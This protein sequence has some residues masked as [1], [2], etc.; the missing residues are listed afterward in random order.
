[1][2][3]D[4]Y[5]TERG[6]C[7]SRAA[8]QCLIKDGGVL[9]NG[10]T[11]VKNSLEVTE[12]DKI[13]IIDIKLPKYVGRGGQKLE[14]ALEL[15]NVDLNGKLC[16]DIGASTGGFT[17]CMLQNG[18]AKVFAVDVG[19]GQLAEKLRSDSRV[20][21]MEQT[22][23]RDF[24][25]P[26]DVFADFIGADVSFIS[27]RLILPHIY[28]LLK[29]GGFAVTLVKPQFEAG[30]E[31]LNKKGIVR[32]ES[33]RMKSVKNIE[34]FAAQC[35]FE[36]IGTSQ[37]PITGGDGN[38]EYLLALKKRGMIERSGEGADAGLDRL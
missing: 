11:A 10:K 13:L 6:M 34:E 38:I 31:N 19:R 24:S 18:A 29:A 5:M 16:V 2:R 28:R 23:I 3:L 21:S 14:R 30:R 20:V 1:M 7:K 17:D 9:V 22:D 15:W 37:S 4:V 33:A 36:I 8:A 26:N 32:S 27:L 25:L 12:A 35:G